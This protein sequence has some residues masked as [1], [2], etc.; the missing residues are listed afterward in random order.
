MPTISLITLI[1]LIWNEKMPSERE[2]ESLNWKVVMTLA[3][4]HLSPAYASPQLSC[5]PE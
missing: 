2:R 3:F 5:A 4:E 1:V